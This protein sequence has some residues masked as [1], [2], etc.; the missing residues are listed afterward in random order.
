MAISSIPLPQ[1]GMDS[2]M[3]GAA[4]TQ[5]ILSNILQGQQ[6]TRQLNISQ[7]AENR[8]QKELPFI[9]QKYQDAHNEARTML[10]LYAQQYKDIHGKALSDAEQQQLYNN[11]IKARMNAAMNPNQ[12]APAPQPGMPA[13]N[14]APSMNGQAGGMPQPGAPQPGMPQPNAQAPM[15]QAAPPEFYAG[16]PREQLQQ[17]LASNK[18]SPADAE[19]LSGFLNSSGQQPGGDVAPPGMSQQPMQPMPMQ[20]NMP[21]PQPGQPQDQSNMQPA[22]QADQGQGVSAQGGAPISNGHITVLD[23]GDKTRYL[24]DSFAGLS[25]GNHEIPKVIP[26]YDTKNGLVMKT[27]PSGKVTVQA[28]T[29]GKT[30]DATNPALQKALASQDAKLVDTL[31]KATAA[32]YDTK[33]TL[34]ELSKVV[35]QPEWDNMRQNPILGNH[36]L[37]WYANYGAPQQKEMVANYQTNSGQIIADMAGKFKGQFRKGEQTLLESMKPAMSDTADVARGKVKALMLMN[38]MMIQRNSATSNFIRNGMSPPDAMS[39]ADS[40][41]KG[42]LIRKM[43]EGQVKSPATTEDKEKSDKNSMSGKITIID[44]NGDEHTIDSNRLEEA[45]KRDPGLRKKGAS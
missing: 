7:Q 15:G 24:E 1:T 9:L 22:P 16:V 27:F 18:I 28:Y 12:G 20:P 37:G 3:Q 26:Y 39:K 35:T 11:F 10:P 19:Q 29:A 42:D 5:N 43:I 2:F 4:G 41:V 38:E 32:G 34:T 25:I 40:Q 14:G 8:Q 33:S 23:P 45:K 44:S 6:R 31:D 17:S 21:A 36:E 13:P 30:G